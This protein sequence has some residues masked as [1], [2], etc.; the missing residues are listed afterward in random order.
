MEET[1]RALAL[2]DELTGLYNRRGFFT[3]AQQQLKTANRTKSR[4]ALLFADF[5]GLKQINDTFGHPEGD[6]ALIEVANATR[7]T[8]RESDIIARIGGDEF[9]VLAV[10]TDGAPAEILAARLQENLAAHNAREGRRYEL[11]LSVGLA[12]YDPERP[13]SIDELLTQADRAMYE[14]K[15][16]NDLA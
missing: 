2:I 6:R 8:F 5:D 16:G 12:R 10:E 9:V 7:E 14:R 3:L 13:C 15:R 11:A 4:L 1:L